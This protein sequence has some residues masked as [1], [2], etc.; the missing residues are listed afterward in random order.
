[1]GHVRKL[2]FIDIFPALAAILRPKQMRVPKVSQRYQNEIW[3][4]FCG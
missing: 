3:P 4:K 2:T 1:M